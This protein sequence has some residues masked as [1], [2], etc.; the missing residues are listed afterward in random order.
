MKTTTN[1]KPFA[2]NSYPSTKTSIAFQVALNT[3][4]KKATIKADS[5]QWKIIKSTWRLLQEAKT[6]GLDTS[7]VKSYTTLRRRVRAARGQHL[8]TIVRRLS[9]TE[10]V[11]LYNMLD[12]YLKKVS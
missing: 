7:D 11:Q 8:E 12:E 1:L 4:G 10:K 9:D 3:Y 6:L 5:Y 2:L